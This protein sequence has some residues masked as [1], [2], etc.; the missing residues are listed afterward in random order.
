MADGRFKGQTQIQFD[1]LQDVIET[2]KLSAL[3]PETG[4]IYIGGGTPKNFIQ[5]TEVSAGIFGYSVS[6]HRYALKI[7][8]DAHHWGGLSGCTFEEAQ[9]WGKIAK[10]ALKTTVFCDATIALPIIANSIEQNAGHEIKQRLRPSF[11]MGQDIKAT[12]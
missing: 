10:S 1:V 6:G 9:S 8:T 5:Q 12:F 7:T 11:E 2:A 3:T 4:V